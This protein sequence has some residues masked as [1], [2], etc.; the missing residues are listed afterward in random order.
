M[1]LLKVYYN[2]E[3][4]YVGGGLSSL[5]LD[6]SPQL[7]GDLDTNAKN[8]QLKATAGG[9]DT[10]V[11]GLTVSLVVGETVA[12]GNT[13]Y[14]KSDGK[15]WKA[16]ATTVATCP[17]LYMATASITADNAGI[18]LINGFARDDS[19]NWTPGA[20]LYQAATAGAITATQPATTANVVQAIGLAITADI[21]HFCPDKVLVEV[22]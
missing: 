12:F 7:G 8:I 5:L 16:N 10:T 14:M 3:W 6:T 15:L 18:V 11:S 22:A 13:L 20:I 17:C 19:Y 1:S 9:A 2:G 4:I 21:I